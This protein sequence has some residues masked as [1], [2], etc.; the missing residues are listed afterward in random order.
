MYE[1]ICVEGNIGAGKTTIARMLSERLHAKLVLEAFEENPFLPIFYKDPE[2]FAFPVELHFLME[3]HRQLKEELSNLNLFS[4]AIIADYSP[5]KSLIFARQT[6]E[7]REFRL[8]QGLYNE[9]LHHLRKPDIIVFIN[10]PKEWLTKSI[11]NR[12][13]VYE[14]DIQI[15][16]LNKVQ[17]SYLSTFNIIQD[18]PI[19]WLETHHINFIEDSYSF[20]RLQELLKRSDLKTGIN[21]IDLE[22]Y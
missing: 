20:D 7:D 12:G 19:I 18:I 22:G 11:R 13:R 4:N 8:F 1:Y 16:Y 15:E 2:R 5:Q 21:F 10:R 9:L 3:R 17:Q 14:M 6:L